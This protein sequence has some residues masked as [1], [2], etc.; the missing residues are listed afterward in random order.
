MAGF[1]AFASPT[2][3]AAH[4]HVFITA[5]V[6][7]AFDAEGRLQ[8]VRERWTFDYDQAGFARFAV[9]RNGRLEDAA[10][11]L[12]RGGPLFWMAEYDYLTRLTAGGRPV[13]H[14]AAREIAVSVAAPRVVVE[15]T[16]PL[17]EPQR[18]TL[19]IGIDVFDPEYFYAIYFDTPGVQPIAAPPACRIG[20]RESANI[21]PVAAMLL[22]RL[23]L[24]ADPKIL[25]D[26]AAGYEVR[27]AID[28]K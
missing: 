13:R 11:A 28:C 20:R 21:D 4:P 15:F 9:D 25:N 12:A 14:D 3:A 10:G 27:V 8:S 17:A 23:N 2:V 24:P 1:V 19:G 7:P 22:R 5:T 16:L 6:M 26:P 18:A